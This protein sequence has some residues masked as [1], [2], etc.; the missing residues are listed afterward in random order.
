MAPS[1]AWPFA[2]AEQIRKL[3]S[4]S[5]ER[6]VLFQTGYGPSG[7][8]HIGTFAEVARTTFVQRAFEQATGLS[9]RLQ[10]FS[11]DMDGLRKVPLNVPNGDQLE[12]HLGKPLHAVPDP[13]G[14]CGSF[15]EHN[16]ARLREFLDA[17]GF[18]Y[19]F[20]SA[21]EAYRAGEFDDGLRV[22]LRNVDDVLAVI[23][24]TLR[25][26][27]RNGWSPFFP[28]C[29]NCGSINSTRV[30]EYHA[31]DDSVSYVC[32][33]DDLGCQATGTTSILGGNAK[34]GWKID[35]ALRWWAFDVDYEMSGKDLIDSVKLSSKIVRVMGKQPPAGLTY[36]LFLDE[37]GKKISKSV[38]K[39][40][41]VE[42]WTD[43]AP[44]ESLLYYLYQKPKTAKRLY[45]DIVPKA[46]DEYLDAL[47]RWPDVDDDSRPR[48]ALWHVYGG[49]PER[50][51]EYGASVD[52]TVVANLI[53]ALGSDDE[54]LLK[55]YLR[56]YDP[57]I[58]AYPDV[59]ASLVHK[60]LTYYREQILPGKQFRDPDADERALLGQV[61]TALEA[62]SAMDESELQS[63]PF[64]VARAAGTEPRE[65]FRSFYEV[66]LGQER[67]PRFGSF[68]NL[69]GRDRVLEMLKDKLAA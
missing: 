44:I 12:P 47:R 65:L 32:D 62:S 59:L 56:R 27:N 48:Q 61:L 23:L 57:Q 46:V 1:A 43:F 69:V 2:E 38:G 28:I 11:D 24:P 40:L 7:L 67:G 41:S 50:V 15:A 9:T 21:T 60:G 18:D 37:E 20:K 52:F 42:H 63:I 51:P 25:E 3:R 35:W 6:P 34:V 33:F 54:D 8:P 19:E 22:L 17:Y 10:T 30:T 64:D 5:E 66:V 4:V 45:W 58:E 26:E 13:F 49:Q 14:C 29:Q 31:D 68:V 36:E 53:S 55:E 39:G 16:N